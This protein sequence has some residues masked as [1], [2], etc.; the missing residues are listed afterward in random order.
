M[1]QLSGAGSGALS[2]VALAEVNFTQA[3]GHLFNAEIA[4]GS[5]THA[6]ST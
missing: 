1:P 3:G 5:W 6:V 4:P 2:G